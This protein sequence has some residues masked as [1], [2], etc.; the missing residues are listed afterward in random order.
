MEDD[1][2]E[3]ETL[4]DAVEVVDA[5]KLDEFVAED[6]DDGVGDTVELFVQTKL[7]D[8]VEEVFPDPLK[9]TP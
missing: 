3:E 9:Q 6:N 1:V 2:L 8:V 7:D 4:S 5:W